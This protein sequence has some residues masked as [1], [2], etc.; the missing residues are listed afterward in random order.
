MPPVEHDRGA[1]RPAVAGVENVAERVEAVVSKD[2]SR[3]RG[4]LETSVPF[5]P[6][7]V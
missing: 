2:Y 5:I 3:D 7:A 4:R 6:R 1:R